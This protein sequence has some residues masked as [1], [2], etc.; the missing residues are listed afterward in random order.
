MVRGRVAGDAAAATWMVHR[1]ATSGSK[2]STPAGTP[3]PP[4]SRR[5][6]STRRSRT[7][8][9]PRRP[10]CSSAWRPRRVLKLATAGATTRA[11]PD[12]GV[13]I[14]FAKRSPFWLILCGVGTRASSSLRRHAVF[15]REAPTPAPAR[16]VWSQVR[17]RAVGVWRRRA[18][19]GLGARVRGARGRRVPFRRRRV[20]EDRRPF[21]RRLVP[22]GPLPEVRAAAE[23]QRG[24]WLVL[25]PD[26]A[27]LPRRRV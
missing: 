1:G 14:T 4:V 18:R 25:Q 7:A 2:L 13:D 20:L 10:T 19:V 12:N 26:V 9:V 5:S 27:L 16:V 6:R 17:P 15:S 8:A 11:R 21:R 24:P 23:R 3:S 22:A